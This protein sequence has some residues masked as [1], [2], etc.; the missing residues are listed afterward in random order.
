M[1]LR[2]SS[3]GTADSRPTQRPTAPLCSGTLPPMVQE[4]PLA[5]LAHRTARFSLPINGCVPRSLPARQPPAGSLHCSPGCDLSSPSTPNAHGEWPP[6][7]RP[8]ASSCARV[9]GL[10]A[11]SR[12]ED[13]SSTV[14]KSR[15][16]ALIRAAAIPHAVLTRA[17]RPRRAPLGRPSGPR[18]AGTHTPPAPALAPG[19]QPSPARPRCSP[20]PC[21]RCGSTLP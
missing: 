21:G 5:G 14:A 20:P 18:L 9:S 4:S 2:L 3:D 11:S 17:S 13:T 12:P 6:A 7:G 8:T 19:L 1:L 10:S 16:G 15:S